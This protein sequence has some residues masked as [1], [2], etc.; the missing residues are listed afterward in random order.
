MPLNAHFPT[1]GFTRIDLLLLAGTLGVLGALCLP[2]LSGPSARQDRVV[3]AANLQRIGQGFLSFSEDFGDRFPGSLDA[4]VG[5]SSGSVT[6]A[7]HFRVISNFLS[8]PRILV[9]PASRRT[10][11]AGFD[12]SFGDVNLSYLVGAHATP[13]KAFE[14]L[15]GDTDI[16]GGTQGTCSYLGQVSVTSFFGI[17]GVPSIYSASWSGTNHLASGNLLLSDGSVVW[18]DSSVLRQ[19]MDESRSEGTR[20]EGNAFH[21]L[22]P[23]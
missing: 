5:G 9:C 18:G 21:A 14:I 23:R 16:E 10:P 11:A 7:S 3:C 6:A 8:S 19:T 22:F 17:R 15:S 20:P 4:R 2:V 12:R 1:S 13:E